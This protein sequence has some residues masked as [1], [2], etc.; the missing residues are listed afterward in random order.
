MKKYRLL[1]FLTV[2]ALTLFGCKQASPH[3]HHYLWHADANGHSQVCACG[4]VLNTATEH[5]DADQ[6]G[7][8][9]ECNYA[10]EMPA[11]FPMLF[12]T[13]YAS[14]FPKDM[15]IDPDNIQIVMYHGMIGDAHLVSMDSAYLDKAYPNDVYCESVEGMEFRYDRGY[16]VYIVHNETLYSAKAAYEKEIIDFNSL[17][18]IFGLHTA[19]ITTFDANA[20]HAVR[21]TMNKN[22]DDYELARYYGTYN[23]FHAV[24]LNYLGMQMAVCFEENVG[25]LRFEYGY[26]SNR[27]RFMNGTESYFLNEALENGIITQKDLY[28][29]FEIHSKS[30]NSSEALVNQLLTAAYELC[31]KYPNDFD[32]E[33]TS[34]CFHLTKYYGQYGDSN[35]F[36]L[37]ADCWIRSGSTTATAEE[38]EVMRYGFGQTAYVLNS[39]TLYTLDQALQHN[40]ISPEIKDEFMEKYYE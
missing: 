2:L 26:Q 30:E 33:V 5:T 1:T 24:S 23:G 15:A 35:I 27:I 22:M 28:D 25:Q 34:A 13:A 11:D 36:S 20:C 9:D 6:N 39:G 4:T 8:C 29:L 16:K 3:P 38:I 37:H 32:R 12:K 17:C 40:L 18:K 10:I 19:N 31:L 21:S 7:H 14:A